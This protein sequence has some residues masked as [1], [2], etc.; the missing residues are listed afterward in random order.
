MCFDDVA[1]I[2]VSPCAQARPPLCWLRRQ[3][4][5]W[6]APGRAMQVDPIKPNFRLPETK[7][8]KLQCDVP[9]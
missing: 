5:Q 1:G 8:L 6:A 7:R 9:L 4:T 3:A 2:F